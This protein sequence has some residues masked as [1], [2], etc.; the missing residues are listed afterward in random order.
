L[1]ACIFGLAAA[2]LL[3]EPSRAKLVVEVARLAPDR[4]KVLSIYGSPGIAFPLTRKLR[5][6]PIGRTPFQW[7]SAYTDRFL[8]AGQLDP[9]AKSG[10]HD[11]ALRRRI[12]EYGRRD[13]FEL[14]DTIRTRRPDVILIGDKGERHWA[15]SHPEIAQV[16][17][18]Y[19]LAETFD[20]VEIWLPRDTAKMTA[21]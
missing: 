7:I 6:T 18:R 15:F 10:I 17:R 19:R 16:L 12:A 5:G 2:W 14:A 20:G 3:Q 21:P 9:A 4:P 1:F 8:S 11:P 13:R